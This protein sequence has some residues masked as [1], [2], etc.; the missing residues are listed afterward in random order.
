MFLIVQPNKIL[1]KHVVPKSHGKV[2]ESI[3]VKALP[4]LLYEA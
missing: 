2:I 3:S 1:V 4:Q